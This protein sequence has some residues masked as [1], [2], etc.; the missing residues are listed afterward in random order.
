M[1]WRPVFWFIGVMLLGNEI[2]DVTFVFHFKGLKG[3]PAQKLHT[4]MMGIIKGYAESSL[5]FNE[6]MQ[7][8]IYSIYRTR[9][10][11]SH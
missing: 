9:L 7:G 11:T 4:D 3:R 6:D 8:K 2:R 5:Q 10:F 1:E